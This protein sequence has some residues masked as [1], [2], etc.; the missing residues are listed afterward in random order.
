MGAHFIYTCKD[1][2]DLSWHLGFRERLLV[3][4]A[5]CCCYFSHSKKFSDFH[6]HEKD[7]IKQMWQAFNL[8]RVLYM[9]SNMKYKVL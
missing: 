3:T 4:E 5:V 7:D 9:L 8:L 1:I 6:L 2:V